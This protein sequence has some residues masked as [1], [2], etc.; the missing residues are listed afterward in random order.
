VNILMNAYE[1]TQ[2]DLIGTTGA[3]CRLT[4]PSCRMAML[5]AC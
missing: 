5:M 3:L 2:F 1:K 4:L